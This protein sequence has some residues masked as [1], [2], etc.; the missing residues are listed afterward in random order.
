MTAPTLPQNPQLVPLLYVLNGISLKAAAAKTTEELSF[1]IV[2]DTIH[3]VPYNRAFLFNF[4]GKSPKVISVSGQANVNDNSPLIKSVEQIISGLKD[5]KEV[6]VLKTDDFSGEGES[7]KWNSYQTDAKSSVLWLPIFSN[8]KQVLGLWL[9]QL[10][11][12]TFTIPLQEIVVLLKDFLMHAYGIAWERLASRYS[13]K[14]GLSF[15][16][17]KW[18]YL[19]ALLALASV[20]IRVPLRIAAPCEIVSSDLYLIRAPL[21]GVIEEIVVLPGQFVKKGD[22]LAIYDPTLLE[23]ALKS[24]EE[25]VQVRKVAVDRATILG[26]QDRQ[27]LNELNQLNSQLQKEKIN[28]ALAAHE[29]GLLKIQAP[30]SGVVVIDSPE[31]WRGRPVIVGEKILAVSNPEKTQVKIWIPESDNIPLNTQEAVKIYLYISPTKSYKSK[32]EYI[33]NEVSLSD[34]DIPSFVAKA[35]WVDNPPSDLKLGLKGTAILYGESV[36]LFYYII[37]KPWFTL[38]NFFGF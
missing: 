24:S 30:Q 19:L 16:K 1:L 10:D 9:E 34:R 6:Q 26:Q 3:L 33:A 14:K 31:D 11:S 2:N 4:E 28:L 23:H 8:R 36:P 17:S 12:S 20:L 27:V 7:S 32:I 38:R 25:D 22:T 13:L 21:A 35:N 5:P 37:R 18:G 29:A 15:S